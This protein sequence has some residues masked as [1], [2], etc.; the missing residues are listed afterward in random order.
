MAKVKILLEKGETEREA[1][2]SLLKAITSHNNGE[3][4]T[5]GFADPAMNDVVAKMQDIHNKMY[6]EMI[7]EIC[8]ALDSEYER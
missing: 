3:V 2:D 4:H 1:E 6:Q 5:D 7:Q 8:D